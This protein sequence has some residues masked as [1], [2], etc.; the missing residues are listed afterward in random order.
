MDELRPVLGD[1]PERARRRAWKF[2]L[3]NSVI[4]RDVD[5]AGVPRLRLSPA[6]N[7]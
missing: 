6:K 1:M 7:E 2:L 3:E 5:S 4:A